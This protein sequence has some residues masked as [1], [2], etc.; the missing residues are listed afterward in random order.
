MKKCVFLIVMSLLACSSVW[1]QNGGDSE[2]GGYP[3]EPQGSEIDG[4]V[5]FFLSEYELAYV[6]RDNCWDGELV[7]PSEVEHD[8]ITYS[9]AGISWNSFRNC[10][11]LTKVTIPHT[12][13][14]LVHWG[15][16]ADFTPQNVPFVGCSA[17]ESIEVEENNPQF[18]SVDDVM[19]TKDKTDLVCYPAGSKRQTYTVPDG[20]ESVYADAFAYN[21]YLVSVTFPNTVSSMYPCF[22]GCTALESVTL[23]KNLSILPSG[24]FSGCTKLKSIEIP[25]SVTEVKANAFE[26]CS[27]LTTIELPSSVTQL[28]YF[29][30]RGCSSLKS[31]VIKGY[32]EETSSRN[33]NEQRFGTIP[34]QVTIYCQPEQMETIQEYFSG[35]VLPLD[36]YQSEA[37]AYTAIESTLKEVP[38]NIPAYDLQGRQLTQKPHKGVYIND[39]R[40][41]VVK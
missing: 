24:I 15:S 19:F 13:I 37:G 1:S 14:Y 29:V 6:R 16:Y 5:Y 9:V 21:P 8:G 38:A 39:G 35:T 33:V 10:Q 18:C 34:E 30:F 2:W 7:I 22:K 4:L 20:V 27:S 28:G 3:D 41:I 17:L 40:K 36:M 31:L 26:D 11:T 12:L 25:T 32:L 23:S